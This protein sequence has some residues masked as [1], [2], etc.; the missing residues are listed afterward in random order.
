[1]LSIGQTVTSSNNNY[2]TAK[3]MQF[4]QSEID[5]IMMSLYYYRDRFSNNSNTT[6]E[7]DTVIRKVRAYKDN[8]SVDS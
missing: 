4:K 5:R 2:S 1:M 3:E 8:Y 7:L 6:D